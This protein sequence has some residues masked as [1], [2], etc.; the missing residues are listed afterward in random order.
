MKRIHASSALRHCCSRFAASF[1]ARPQQKVEITPNVQS[2]DGF[3]EIN[4]TRIY[5]TITGQGVP[6]VLIHGYPL[7]GD[8]FVK[9]R[10]FLSG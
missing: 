8:L 4:G 1:R 5:Y 9:E 6:L 7:N 10:Q 3:V 2:T